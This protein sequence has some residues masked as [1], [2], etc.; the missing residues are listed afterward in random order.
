MKIIEGIRKAGIDIEEDI[1][2]FN[3]KGIVDNIIIR[4]P[5]GIG[6]FIFSD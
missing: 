1:T 2:A 6:F 3:E 4:E 5:G